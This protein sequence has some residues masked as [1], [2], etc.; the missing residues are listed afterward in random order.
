MAIKCECGKLI[1]ASNAHDHVTSKDEITKCNHIV[2][3]KMDNQKLP[4][5]KLT[6]MFG[7][8]WTLKD[9]EKQ[10][11]LIL[12]CNSCGFTTNNRQEYGRH[13]VTTKHRH[14]RFVQYMF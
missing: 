2:K 12:T 13:Y 14:S 6:D 1:D 11:A 4:K 9:L 5:K 3:Q 8:K 10:E 7:G